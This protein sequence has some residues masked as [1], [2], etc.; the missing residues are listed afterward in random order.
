MNK[1]DMMFA[2]IKRIEN[3]HKLTLFIK[4]IFDYKNFNDYNYIFRVINE[5]NFVIMDIYDNVT[6]NRF[7]RYIFDFNIDKYDV[8]C[9]CINNVFVTMINIFNMDDSDNKLYKL[10]FLFSDKNNDLIKYANTFLEKTF[11]DILDDIINKPTYL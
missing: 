11:I 4:N 5:D 2:F 1:K 8:K 3:E 7:N 9:K 10:A 6:E